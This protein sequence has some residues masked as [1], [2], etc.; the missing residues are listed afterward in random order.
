MSG[1]TVKV[2]EGRFFCGVASSIPLPPPF[3]FSKFHFRDWWTITYQEEESNKARLYT[4]SVEKRLHQTAQD[5]YQLAARRTEIAQGEV[6]S[7]VH[8]AVNKAGSAHGSASFLWTNKT[9]HAQKAVNCYRKKI[10]CVLAFPGFKL[11]SD[12]H[13]GAIMLHTAESFHW[14][15]K[16]FCT[17]LWI[18]INMPV[19]LRQVIIHWKYLYLNMQTHIFLYISVYVCIGR[20]GP[21][22]NIK[23]LH[24]CSVINSCFIFKYILLNWAVPDNNFI[25]C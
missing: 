8:G 22:C 16:Y 21:C 17:I 9:I 18:L 25:L 23:L 12:H 13:F 10:I 2:W 19:S 4:Q 6:L 1:V 7:S 14:S 11:Y 20:A 3:F 15:S 24:N 5:W